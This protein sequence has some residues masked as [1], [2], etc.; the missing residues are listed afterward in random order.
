MRAAPRRRPVGSGPA[1][2]LR[3]GLRFDGEWYL[4]R[5][6]SA[7]FRFRSGGTELTLAPGTTFVELARADA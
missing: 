2:L 1:T 7:P 5:A 4:G 6:P 3:A